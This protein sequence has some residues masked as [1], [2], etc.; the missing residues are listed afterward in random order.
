MNSRIY[1]GSSRRIQLDGKLAHGLLSY[2]LCLS[3]FLGMSMAGMATN[4]QDTETR[5]SAADTLLCRG[6]YLLYDYFIAAKSA[7]IL[8]AVRCSYF[9]ILVCL[10]GCSHCVRV[11]CTL[12]AISAAIYCR[13]YRTSWIRFANCGGGW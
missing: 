11:A 3:G 4:R 2:W 5:T 12:K 10:V 7:K 13:K 1:L 8:R 9:S 6:Y